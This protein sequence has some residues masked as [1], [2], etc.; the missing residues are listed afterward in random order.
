[1]DLLV[2]RGVRLAEVLPPLA[3]AHDDVLHGKILEHLR[4]DLA[5]VGALLLEVH[6]L[7]A[8]GDAQVLERAGGG[9]DVAGGD[10]DQRVAP[11]G[12]GHDLLHLLGELLR[13]GGGHVHLPVSGDNGLAVTTIHGLILPSYVKFRFAPAPA[14]RRRGALWMVFSGR[15]D[16]AGTRLTCP[17]GTPR[18]EAPCPPGTPAT[19][20]RRWKCG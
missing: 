4:G 14:F 6:V 5:G 19:R 17:A 20:R 7:R 12:A 1:M 10:A 16:A 18:R 8:H 11:L 13:L 2:H 15:G 3:V 9:G